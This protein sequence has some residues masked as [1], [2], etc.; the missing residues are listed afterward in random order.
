MVG[1]LWTDDQ[2]AGERMKTLE[3]IL[4]ILALA[5]NLPTNLYPDRDITKSLFLYSLRVTPTR[6]DFYN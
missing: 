3:T 5:L 6:R 2:K 4:K 1:L